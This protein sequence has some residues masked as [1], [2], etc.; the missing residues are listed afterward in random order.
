MFLLKQSSIGF[1]PDTKLYE[2]SIYTWA[3][4]NKLYPKIIWHKTYVMPF[5]DMISYILYDV[6][7][8]GDS[9]FSLEKPIS[10]DSHLEAIDRA[11][12]ASSPVPPTKSSK[13]LYSKSKGKRMKEK[14]DKSDGGILVPKKEKVEKLD[15]PTAILGF[16]YELVLAREAKIAFL[17]S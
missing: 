9:V 10:L 4:L 1:N 3:S 7:A 13:K 11:T 2:F 6:Q 16:T 8:N 5:R 15:L 17:L 12:S 14:K